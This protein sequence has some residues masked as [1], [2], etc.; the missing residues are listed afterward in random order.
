MVRNQSR[1]PSIPAE[2]MRSLQAIMERP[3]FCYIERRPELKRW[4]VGLYNG[5]RNESG[6]LRCA[7][8]PG[9]RLSEALSLASEAP[10]V[11]VDAVPR[12]RKD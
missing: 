10:V 3:D 11:D 6:M 9:D 7:A 2:V 1:K 5:S 12:G 8:Y 4:Y